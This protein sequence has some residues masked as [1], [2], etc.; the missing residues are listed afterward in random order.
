M[1]DNK[2][3]RELILET[4]K[5]LVAGRRSDEYGDPNENFSAIADMWTA[6]CRRKGSYFMSAHDVAAFTIM[7]KLSRIAYNPKSWDSWVDIAGYAAL[8][9]ETVEKRND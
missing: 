9:A 2:P 6:Y 7:I 4:A 1:T 5:G 3:P 8:G